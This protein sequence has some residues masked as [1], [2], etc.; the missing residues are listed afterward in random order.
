MKKKLSPARTNLGLPRLSRKVALD[1]WKAEQRS[2]ACSKL[3]LPNE[4][5]EALFA[6]LSD[7]LPRNGCDHTLTLT[8]SWLQNAAMPVDDVLIWL[9]D[10]GGF[11]DCEALAN[12][13][14][15]WREAINRRR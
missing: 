2:V 12:A 13:E 6:V 14:Q 7:E 4:P 1:H 10:N 3:P 5:M 9:R 15:A 11:C 8:C